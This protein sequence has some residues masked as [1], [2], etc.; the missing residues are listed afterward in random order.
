[1]S[2]GGHQASTR[3]VGG[4]EVGSTSFFCPVH[5]MYG[6]VN[7]NQG[8]GCFACVMDQHYVQCSECGY[9]NDP[10]RCQF[11]SCQWPRCVRNVAIA[12]GSV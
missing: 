6:A 11:A 9:W 10:R 12:K 4:R 1:M 2:S 8:I 7:N 3:C 5:G